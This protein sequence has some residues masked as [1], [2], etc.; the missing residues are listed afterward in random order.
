LHDVQLAIANECDDWHPE[1]VRSSHA[2][3]DPTANKAIRYVD[4][5]EAKLAEL[6]KEETELVDFIGEALVIIQAV[7]DGLGEDYADAL[8]WRYIDGATWRYIQDMYGVMRRTG[9][10]RICVAFD[11]IDSLGVTRVLAGDFEL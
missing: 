1:G 6:R 7:R 3:G 10:R 11:W 2:I 5:V 4:V 8:E 9:N